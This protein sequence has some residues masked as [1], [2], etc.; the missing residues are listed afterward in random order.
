VSKKI[1][2]DINGVTTN[3]TVSEKFKFLQD[4]GYIDKNANIKDWQYSVKEVDHVTNNNR[5]KK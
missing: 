5:D 3:M 4:L 2:N 1:Y